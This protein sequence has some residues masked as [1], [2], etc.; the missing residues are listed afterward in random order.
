MINFMVINYQGGNR[1]SK[2][3]LL[4]LLNIQIQN[5]IELGW[6]IKNI[7]VYSNFDYEF[8]GVK[9]TNIG[10]LN[11]ICLTGSKMFYLLEF[12]KKNKDYD[13]IWSHDLDAL[14]NVWFEVP[15]FNDV[16]AAQYSRPKFNGGSI[17]WKPQA[18]DIVEEVVKYLTEHKE[19]KEE[20]T[21]NKLFKNHPDRITT[22][23]YTYNVGCSGF[24]PRYTQSIKP[25][26]VCHFHPANFIAWETHA[27]NRS[28]LG[29]TLSKRL[30]NL[31]RSYYP[32]LAVELSEKGKIRQQQ[33][34]K[35]IEHGKKVR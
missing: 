1:H 31:V 18:I 22:L 4:K 33:K 20:P 6:D 15:E 16:G 23:N 12:M 3:D 25:I 10:D 26:H 5:S 7:V 13:V 30:E 19:M 8:M 9:T 34:K 27:L 32:N 24:I 14:Q 35:E 28:V 11:K 29:P 17:F 21:L 2:E